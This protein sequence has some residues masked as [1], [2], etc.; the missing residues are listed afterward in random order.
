MKRM[1]DDGCFTL[2]R[3]LVF[4]VRLSIRRCWASAVPNR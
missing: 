2:V 1:M 4:Y 3:L